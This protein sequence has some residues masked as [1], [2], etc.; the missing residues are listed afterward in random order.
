MKK[1]FN[2]S[3]KVPV[4][5]QIEDGGTVRPVLDAG[6][7]QIVE[8]DIPESSYDIRIEEAVSTSNHFLNGNSISNFSGVGGC[9]GAS[10]IN[11]K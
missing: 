2:V 5:H 11:Y 9:G 6:G 1:K 8:L 3:Y 7:S 4:A 10:P